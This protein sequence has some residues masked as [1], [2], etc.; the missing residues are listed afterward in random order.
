MG[1]IQPGTV[2]ALTGLLWSHT[3][4]SIIRLAIIYAQRSPREWNGPYTTR[5]SACSDESTVEPHCSIDRTTSHNTCSEESSGVAWG[6]IQPGTV[7]ALTGLLWSLTA[8]SIIRLAII[9][10]RR[11]PREW[12]GYYT[13]R[14]SACSDGST[15]E[16]HRSIHRATRHN[17]CAE[18]S[19]GV[20]WVL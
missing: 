9:H 4:A 20:E 15:V 12:N 13:T 8:A 14:H 16:P 5:H 7:R 1:I 17:I 11:S 10:A 3:A 19:T 2:R 6:I 18:E